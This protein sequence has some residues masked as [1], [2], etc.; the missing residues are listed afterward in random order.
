[1]HDLYVIC[2]HLCNKLF[3]FPMHLYRDQQIRSIEIELAIW[4]KIKR[5]STNLIRKP[6]TEVKSTPNM[7]RH[8]CSLI[9]IESFRSSSW[10]SH[11][12]R[13]H[14]NFDVLTQYLHM[15]N[16]LHIVAG[17][18]QDVSGNVLEYGHHK[19]AD[20]QVDFVLKH[21]LRTNKIGMRNM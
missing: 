18:L 10:I 2:Y 16:V 20:G 13:T 11:L 21:V 3:D 14:C 17:Q 8:V 5:S 4:I 1:M 7:S 6:K 19:C 9:A 12:I 15:S